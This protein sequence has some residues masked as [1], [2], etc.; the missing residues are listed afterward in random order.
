M[1][2]WFVVRR[3]KDSAWMVHVL[4]QQP[5]NYQLDG[6]MT[7][8]TAAQRVAIARAVRG[9]ALQLLRAPG[10]ALGRPL[11]RCDLVACSNATTNARGAAVNREVGVVEDA[12]K[13]RSAICS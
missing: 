4:R 6:E 13:S 9:D 3:K 11:G 10:A 7:T 12:R 1:K 2:T 5:E 8:S